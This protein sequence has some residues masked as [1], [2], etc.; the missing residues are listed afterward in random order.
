MTACGCERL[1]KR[2]VDFRVAGDDPSPGRGYEI[3]GVEHDVTGG[4]GVNDAPSRIDN[5]HRRAEAIERGGEARGLRCPEIDQP[6]DQ[7]RPADMWN[8]EPHAP[9]GFIVDNTI[10]LVAKHPEQCRAGHRFIE[11]RR[12]GIH[13]ALWVDPLL[14]KPR[15]QELLVRHDILH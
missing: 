2:L 10:A 6:A 8:D 12:Y 7:H 11:H 1:A 14:I 9:A 15:L 4:V 13:H 3:A 5:A